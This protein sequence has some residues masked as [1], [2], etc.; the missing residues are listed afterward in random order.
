MHVEGSLDGEFAD[1]GEALSGVI[2]EPAFAV[3]WGEV[4]R[5]GA[6]PA[7]APVTVA[8]VAAGSWVCTRS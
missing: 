6:H 2:V 7:L 3:G 8:F 5:L 1:L 4:L